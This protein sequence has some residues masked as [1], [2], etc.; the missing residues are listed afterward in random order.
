VLFRS[1][2]TEPLTALNIATQSYNGFIVQATYEPEDERTTRDDP[3]L[4]TLE[5]LLTS[6]DEKG[7]LYLN[8]YNAVFVNSGTRG[9]GAPGSILGSISTR[10]GDFV[11]SLT[12][13]YN[14]CSCRS[15]GTCSSCPSGPSGRRTWR[16]PLRP[17]TR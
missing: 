15:R 3:G 12:L 11:D 2:V 14:R 9:L 6:T 16:I 7:R 8:L 13:S 10:M 5:G 4:L 17:R 1:N